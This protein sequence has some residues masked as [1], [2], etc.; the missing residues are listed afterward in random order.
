MATK[1][2]PTYRYE[3]YIGVPPHDVWRGLTDGELTKHYAWGTR[4]QTSLAQGAPYAFVGDGDWKVVDGE[5]LE[6]QPQRRL[7]LSWRAH[8]DDATAGDRASRVTYEL[9][10]AGAQTT[11]L[12]VVHD[13][14]DS[15]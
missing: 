15:E 9:E 10:P 7:V 13:D 11:K 1:T 8:W 4:L 6:V 5:V 2:H 14:F 3:I 12:R